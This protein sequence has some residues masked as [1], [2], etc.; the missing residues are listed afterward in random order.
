MHHAAAADAAA[1]APDALLSR[2]SSS[3]LD[4]RAAASEAINAA[5][6]SPMFDPE[7]GET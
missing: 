7:G 2:C 4:V 1:L 6:G 5:S 3:R